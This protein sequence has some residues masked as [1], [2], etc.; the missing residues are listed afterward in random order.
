MAEDSKL[1]NLALINGVAQS[2]RRKC[3]KYGWRGVAKIR[4]QCGNKYNGE[5]A[6]NRGSIS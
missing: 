2:A 4:P 6:C 1:F 3:I 5:M